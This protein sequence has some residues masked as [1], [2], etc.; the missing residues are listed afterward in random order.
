MHVLWCRIFG[1]KFFFTSFQ[2]TGRELGV[3]GI[4]YD[5]GDTF[6]HETTYCTRCGV[7]RAYIMEK[8]RTIAQQTKC[9]AKPK[10]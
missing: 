5:V 7:E 3:T 4:P 9:A 2:K 8:M 1:H 10:S 6:R